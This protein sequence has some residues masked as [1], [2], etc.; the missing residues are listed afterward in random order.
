MHS[1]TTYELYGSPV[2]Q[3]TRSNGAILLV[4]DISE[5]S[6]MEQ[7]RREFTANVSHELKTPLTTILG[8]SQLIHNGMVK[9]K[10]IPDF[11]GRIEQEAT[12]L[13]T[14]IE[15]I[16]KQSKLDECC[17]S[18]DPEPVDLRAVCKE[19]LANLS[20]A[21]EQKHITS[22][23]SGTEHTTILA[24]PTMVE[25]M[26][27]NLV[28]NAVK[29]NTDGG[30]IALTVDVMD[31]R[32]RISVSDTGI[33]IPDEEQERIFERFYRVDKSHSRRIGGTGL[34]LS[35][36]KHIALALSADISVNSCVGQGTT[37][38]VTF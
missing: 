20:E 27:Y 38:T 29:Y 19:V 5:R 1:N 6:R 10:D 35:I 23:F 3:D 22:T 8:Y 12:R 36:V 30:T 17:V 26:V 21:M 15:D 13:I 32:P 4:F 16:I 14:L 9:G 34:G 2:I 37:M 25:E 7:M 28:D 24:D 18:S 31:G 33:G 11:A